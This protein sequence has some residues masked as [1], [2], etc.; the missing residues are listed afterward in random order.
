M[1]SLVALYIAGVV[2]TAALGVLGAHDAPTRESRRVWARTAL[3]APAWPVLLL[4][5]IGAGLLWLLNVAR[6][7]DS[8]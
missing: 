6:T 1:T 3:A 8:A 7:G 5:G 2:A 4:W